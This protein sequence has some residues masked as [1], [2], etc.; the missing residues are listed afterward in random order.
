[1]IN[2]CLL[3]IILFNYYYIQEKCCDNKNKTTKDWRDLEKNF[4]HENKKEEI[5]H[6][7]ICKH[8]NTYGFKENK[9]SCKK[10][11]E[12]RDFKKNSNNKCSRSDKSMKNKCSETITKTDC[13]KDTAENEKKQRRSVCKILNLIILFF[14]K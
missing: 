2:I 10:L 7:D 11:D 9:R 3:L 4:K 6:D 8:L 5:K 14:V 13:N 1:M 12:Y